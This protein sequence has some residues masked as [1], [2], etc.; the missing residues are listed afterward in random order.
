[1]KALARAVYQRCDIL[2]LDD[3]FSALDQRTQD[4]VIVNL[5][6]PDG[7]LRHMHTTVFLITN[8]GKR[9]ISANADQKS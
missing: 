4:R 6:S 5:L 3:P 7:L 8:A 1:M 9:G 2:V